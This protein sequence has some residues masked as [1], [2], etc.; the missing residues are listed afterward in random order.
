MLEFLSKN[1]ELQIEKLFTI[2][3]DKSGKQFL[4]FIS[5]R[6]K[7]KHDNYELQKIQ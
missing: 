5:A 3:G 1:H 6:N 4:N 7:R 2:S